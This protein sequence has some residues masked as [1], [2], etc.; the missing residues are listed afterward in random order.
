[1]QHTAAILL[2]LSLAPS[3]GPGDAWVAKRVREVR[4][5]DT[6]AW[7]KIPWSATLLDAAKDAKG[8]DRLMFVFS[9]EGN[10]DTGRC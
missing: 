2:A 6:D 7:R 8:E 5:G 3:A 4:E 9:H 10:I 1:M